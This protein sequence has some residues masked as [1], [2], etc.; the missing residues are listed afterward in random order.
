MAI[1][2]ARTIVATCDGCGAKQ[3]VETADEV[4]GYS[5]EVRCFWE[6]G[7]SAVVDWFACLPPCIKDAVMNAIEAS[8]AE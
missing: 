5:G 1:R 4:L 2:K 8:Q 6:T 3:I 7:G